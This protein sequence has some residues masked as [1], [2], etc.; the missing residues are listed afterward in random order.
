MPVPVGAGNSSNH[1]LVCFECFCLL[2]A[3]LP[4]ALPPLPGELMLADDFRLPLHAIRVRVAENTFRTLLDFILARIEGEL[5]ALRDVERQRSLESQLGHALGLLS[6]LMLQLC[7]VS[8]Q[9]MTPSEKI[10]LDVFAASTRNLEELHR[11]CLRDL[12]I[13][14]WHRHA[15]PETDESRAMVDS[16]GITLDLVAYHAARRTTVLVGRA[17]RLMHQ[18]LN[19]E[20]LSGSERCCG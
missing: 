18:A 15:T 13:D 19:C 3:T 12:L 11:A 4:C 14:Y 5:S 1:R 10:W 20:Q 17:S 9:R 2:R 16:A 7:H 6:L 8:S